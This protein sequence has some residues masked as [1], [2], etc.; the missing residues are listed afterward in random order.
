MIS[1]VV[2]IAVVPQQAKV[3][4]MHMHLLNQPLAEEIRFVFA[5]VHVVLIA[6]RGVH[7]HERM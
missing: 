4:M 5:E 3:A 1:G 7:D 2:N 6:Q